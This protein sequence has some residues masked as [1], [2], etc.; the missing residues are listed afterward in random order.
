MKYS[1]FIARI[2]CVNSIGER[3][4]EDQSCHKKNHIKAQNQ[5]CNKFIMKLL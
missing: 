2:D 4:S 5:F 3:E 1:L